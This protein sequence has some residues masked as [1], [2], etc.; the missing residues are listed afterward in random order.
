[1]YAAH[2]THP[3]WIPSKFDP[4]SDGSKAGGCIHTLPGNMISYDDLDP[5]QPL[6]ARQ[7]PD[8]PLKEWRR[9]F[10][11]GTLHTSSLMQFFQAASP[12]FLTIEQVPDT[13]D[14]G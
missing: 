12:Y 7:M 1:M 4:K 10:E 14:L 6:T 8:K 3:H 5:D 9:E 13:N 2:F 11:A